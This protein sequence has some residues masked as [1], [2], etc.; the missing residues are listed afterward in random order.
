MPYTLIRKELQW[1][2]TIRFAD[3][4]YDVDAA[5]EA[6]EKKCKLPPMKGYHA[7]RKALGTRQAELPLWDDVITILASHRDEGVRKKLLEEKGLTAEQVEAVAL[8]AAVAEV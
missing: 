1:P 6:A 7:L 5:P 8:A 4:R 2:Q 3:V